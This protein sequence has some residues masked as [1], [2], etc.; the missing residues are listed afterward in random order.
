MC[1]AMMLWPSVEELLKNLDRAVG[2]P[3]N[4]ASLVNSPV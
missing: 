2:C 3:G 1:H 4:F